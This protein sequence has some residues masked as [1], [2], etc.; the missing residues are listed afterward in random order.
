MTIFVQNNLAEMVKEEFF[1]QIFTAPDLKEVIDELNEKWN[2]EQRKRHEFWAEVDE[3][4]K[5]EF[6]N[7]EIIYHSP[8]YGRHWMANTNILTELLPYV[9][10]N[11]LG[12]VAVEKVMIRLTRNDYEP[13]ICFWTT[14]KAQLFQA[15]QS[16][17][18][19]PDFVVEILS[20][21]TKDR[22]RGIKFKDYAQHSITEYWIID[23]ES[24]TVEQY[25]LKDRQYD[26][27]L[28][29]NKGILVSIA[30]KGFSILV[31]DIF[32]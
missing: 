14:E 27:N 5:A 9:K 22:D 11:N 7:G 25:I 3:N 32:K 8:V 29:L 18:P 12:K 30:I 4:L 19:P 1:S 21:T 2:A 26:L 20:D 17:F 28:K 15:K 24:L 31:E 6:I 10:N 13:D 23:V 16:A